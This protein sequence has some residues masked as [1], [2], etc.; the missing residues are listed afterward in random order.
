M[1]MMVGGRGMRI[2]DFESAWILWSVSEM[3]GICG[4]NLR[5][6]LNVA[7]ERRGS[8]NFTGIL[9]TVYDRASGEA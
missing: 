5:L 7:I 1:W 6:V 9:L 3:L 4:S 8:T 2:G